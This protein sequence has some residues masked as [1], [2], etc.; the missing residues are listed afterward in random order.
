MSLA[1][2]AVAAALAAWRM[3][4]WTSTRAHPRAAH[5]LG[6]RRKGQT[7]TRA[8][9]LALLRRAMAEMR[10]GH[11]GSGSRSPLELPTYGAAHS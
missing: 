11:S 1:A 9:E 4:R 5:R 10:L 2:F 8:R 7:S 3:R 6:F